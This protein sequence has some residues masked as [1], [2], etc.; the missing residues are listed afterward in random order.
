MPIPYLLYALKEHR[1][2]IVG[3]AHDRW[4]IALVALMLYAVKKYRTGRVNK[5]ERKM[6]AKVIMMTVGE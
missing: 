3:G 2:A 1:E 6:D 4:P 5:W